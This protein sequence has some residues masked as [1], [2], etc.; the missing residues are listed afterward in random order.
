[1]IEVKFENQWRGHAPG[2]VV[3]LTDERAAEL[4]ESGHCC[5]NDAEPPKKRGRPSKP[6][7]EA[8]TESTGTEP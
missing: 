6:R 8:E 5:A 7:P 1:M 2:T 4:I 3:E